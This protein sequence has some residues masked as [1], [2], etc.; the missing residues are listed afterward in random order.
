MK[1][2]NAF[3][4]LYMLMMISVIALLASQLVKS[5]FVGSQFI[6]TMIQRERAEMLALSGLE[7]AMAQLAYDEKDDEQP[8]SD[9]A[10][11]DQEPEKKKKKGTKALLSRLLPNLN[12][13]QTFKLDERNDGI[14]GSIKFCISCESGKININEAFDFK[15]MEF[16]KE[17]DAFLRGLELRGRIPA[18]EMLNRMVEFFKQRKRKLDDISE[19]LA[20]SGFQTLDIFYRPPHLPAKG[21]KAEPNADLALQ[22]IFTI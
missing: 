19:L 21:K 15:K 11:K 17:Y 9:P 6:N 14:D 1:H 8:T 13:W 18:G 3:V 16:K 4:V 20:I 5:V 7:L 2:A 22:D 10:A 12:R